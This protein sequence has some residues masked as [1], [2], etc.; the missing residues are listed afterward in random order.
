M[1][2]DHVRGYE[3]LSNFHLHVRVRGYER[4]GAHVSAYDDAHARE[5]AR[6]ADAGDYVDAHA[7]DHGSEYGRAYV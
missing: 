3:I 2:H 5:F 4:E 6:H 7:H 1:F